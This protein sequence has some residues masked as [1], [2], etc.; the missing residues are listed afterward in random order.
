M[1]LGAN[2]W[3]TFWKVTFPLIL[4]GIAG[5]RAARVQPVDRRLRHHQL[6]GRPDADLPAVHLR[7]AAAR[8]PGAGQRHRDHHLRRRRRLRPADDPVAAPRRRPGLQGQHGRL[9]R[10]PHRR[11]SAM[12]ETAPRPVSTHRLPCPTTRS[13]PPV[14][15]RITNLDVDRGEGSWLITRDGTRYLDYSS[16]SASP[17]PATP[18]RGSRRPSRPRRPSSSTAQQNITYHEPG[19]RL[20][21]RLRDG[22]PGRPVAGVPVE[23]G[24]GGGRGLGQAGAGRD[25]AAG[26]HG[27]PLRLPRPDRADHGADHGQGRLSRLRSS[28]CP[29]SVYHTAYPYCYRAAGGAHAPDACTCDWEAQL[30]L[31]FHQF[32]YP[33]RVAAIIIEPVLGEGGY[34]VPP[35]GLPAAAPRDHPPAR[36]PAHRRRGPDRVRA[37]R[38]DVRGPALGRRAGHPR[39][40]QGHRVRPAAVRHPRP[41]RAHGRLEARHPR[42]HVRRQRRVVRGGERHA[43]RHRGRG[44]RRQRARARRPV[45]G[46]PRAGWPA[47]VPVDRR[48]ARPRPDGRASSSSSRASATAGS[49]TRT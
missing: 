28:R 8:H 38:R 27:V 36:H 24:R 19:L 37:D 14:W 20:Y 40:G 12:V 39:H 34:V 26:D 48:C 9:T 11:P 18:I 15:S 7:V 35:P 2:E 13:C 29:G 49:R 3:T 21:D 45:P 33:D 41:G 25:R 32:I 23:L 17:T 47:D 42:R 30:D 5:G 44:P 46:R 43:R 16:G 31:T 22:P 4:P 10:R 6:H 1:D